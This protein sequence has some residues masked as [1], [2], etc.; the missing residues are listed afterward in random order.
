M[1]IVRMKRM[2][3]LA[4]LDDKRDIMHRLMCL[5]CVEI[6]QPER[7]LADSE[8]SALVAPSES[9]LPQL[10]A[11]L[12][13]LQSARLTLSRYANAKKGRNIK[14]LYGNRPPVQPHKRASAV[15]GAGY[16]P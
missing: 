2:R 1:S 12:A 15:D 9:D 3:L 16:T 7:L 8:W 11:S 14:N 4:L 10:K 13:V 6:G 5:G